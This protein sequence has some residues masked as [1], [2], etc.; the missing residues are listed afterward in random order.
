MRITELQVRRIQERLDR[1]RADI[2]SLDVQIKH[3][4]PGTADRLIARRDELRIQRDE[5]LVVARV[6]GLSLHHE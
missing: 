3:R 4:A 5:L 1:H 6:L 2:A